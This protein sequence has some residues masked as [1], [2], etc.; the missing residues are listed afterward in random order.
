MENEELKRIIHEEIDKRLAGGIKIGTQSIYI[1][2]N[3]INMDSNDITEIGE[4]KFGSGN[5]V[6]LYREGAGTLATDDNVHIN[7]GLIVDGS[8]DHGIGMV[9]SVKI[10]VSTLYND[11]VLDSENLDISV[12]GQTIKFTSEAAGSI[13]DLTID[14]HKDWLSYSITNVGTLEADSITFGASSA[15][16]TAGNEGSIVLDGILTGG[17]IESILSGSVS[18]SSVAIDSNKS[19]G[20][21]DITHVGNFSATTIS[22]DNYAWFSDGGTGTINLF[23]MLYGGTIYPDAYYNQSAI[24]HGNL[25]ELDNENH[26]IAGS[27]LAW[28]GETVS[29]TL[30]VHD[31]PIGEVTI[32]ADKSWGWYDLNDVGILKA[33]TIEFNNYAAFLDGGISTITLLGTLSGGVIVPGTL[34]HNNL[35]NISKEDHFTAG[36]NLSWSGDTLNASGGGA[37]SL[38]DL[39]IDGDKDWQNYDVTNFGT[40]GMHGA[41]VGYAILTYTGTTLNVSTGILTTNMTA[42]NIYGTVRYS[43]IR[44]KDLV[45]EKCGL[46]FVIGDHLVLE[47]RGFDTSDAGKEM[48]AVP[49]HKRCPT[50]NPIKSFLRWIANGI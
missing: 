43:D 17:T 11:I 36:S 4:L 30:Y 13:S 37:G 12:I 44:F 27:G 41:N 34:D 42:T 40:I 16:F 21:Y 5:D 24:A 3:S 46:P 7:G 8:F 39:V 18:L 2:P 28:D 20:W 1:Y 10:G 22:L 6:N 15:Y 50:N 38:S 9:T 47:V 29:A 26:F 19:W 35:T 33:H 14:T 45:C 23:G 48:L 49:L 32:N 25:G 31:V